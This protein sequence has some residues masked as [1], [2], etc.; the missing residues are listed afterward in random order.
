M[1]FKRKSF[2]TFKER[3]SEKISEEE[4]ADIYQ[5]FSDFD[6]LDKD[7]KVKIKID[8]VNDSP[9]NRN[10]EY[11]IK[12]FSEKKANYLTNV[13][14]LGEQLDLYLVS[15]DI[16]SLWYG[17]GKSKET[18]EGL[19]YVILIAISKVS[20]DGFRQ[21]MFKSKRNPLSQFWMG[22]DFEIGQIVRFAPSACNSQPWMVESKDNVLTIYRKSKS[23]KIGIMPKNTAIYFN[24]IDMGIFLLFLELSLLNKDI[25]FK[26]DL[27]VDSQEYDKPVKLAQYYLTEGNI[28]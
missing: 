13:G 23:G 16:G 11:C 22:D 10:C 7:I 9:C 1:I 5:A 12:I 14:Y 21:D 20:K 4:I 2:H 8:S 26:R 24:Q 28:Q 3:I 19:N 15:K 17:I 18:Y 25:A 27:F 6:S